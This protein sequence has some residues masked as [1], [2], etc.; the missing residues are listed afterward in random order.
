MQALYVHL[1]MSDCIQK[2]AKRAALSVSG[3]RLAANTLM[4]RPT[5]HNAE[6]QL[7]RFYDRVLA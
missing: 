1:E 5:E 4:G 7:G 2:A 3:D 6:R